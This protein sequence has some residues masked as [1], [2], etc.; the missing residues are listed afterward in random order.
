MERA[1]N[2]D[3]HLTLTPALAGALPSTIASAAATEA[4]LITLALAGWFRRVSAVNGVRT[5]SVHRQARWAVTVVVP[6]FLLVVESI[7]PRSLLADWSALAAGAHLALPPS[8]PPD[9]RLHDKDH[10][11]L[12]FVIA[13]RAG[14]RVWK[15]VA[16][17]PRCHM[18]L[19]AVNTVSALREAK[20]QRCAVVG[21]GVPWQRRKV[22]RDQFVQRLRPSSVS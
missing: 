5:F 19:C 1:A 17:P 22:G 3:R 21:E 11:F 12:W 2:V 16:H 13:A 18:I 6:L 10:G 9:L 4:A 20:A 7:G 8:R 15:C 14:S